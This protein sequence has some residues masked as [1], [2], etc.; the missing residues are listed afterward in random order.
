MTIDDGKGSK[1]VREFVIL[2]LNKSNK[3]QKFYVYFKSPPD[4]RKMAFLVWKT[5]VRMMIDG[6][7][8]LP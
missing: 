6:Y 8:F 7:G 5:L 2:R 1:R 4:V 3:D